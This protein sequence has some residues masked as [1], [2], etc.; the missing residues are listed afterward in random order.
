MVSS[1]RYVIGI[2]EAGR[3]PLAGPVAV[4]VVAIDSERIS[5]PRDYFHGVRDSKKLSEKGRNS[6]FQKLEGDRNSG[7]LVFVATLVSNETIDRK[8]I[9]VA[10]KLGIN[11]SLEKLNLIPGT[12]HVLL[13]GGLCAPD[14]YKNQRTIIRGD[15]SEPVIALASIV[16]K[17][18]RDRWLISI[19]RKYPDYGLEKHKGYGTRF[20]Y[21]ALEKL[22]LSP[23]HRRTFCRK[24]LIKKSPR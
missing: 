14:R 17:V 24:I 20:H 16:A 9:A 13:D 22:G 11:E 23:I 3:G 19:A 10:I 7:K 4:G 18:V 15:E 2:D 1:P 21:L 12:C 6:W 5:D 8:G